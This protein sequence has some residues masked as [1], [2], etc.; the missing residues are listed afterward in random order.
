MFLNETNQQWDL[1]IAA[2]ILQNL[3]PARLK[4]F[5]EESSK[6]CKYLAANIETNEDIRSDILDTY[7]GT[8]EIKEI[9]LHHTVKPPKEW[10]SILS[11]YFEITEQKEEGS[12]IYLLGTSKL[13]SKDFT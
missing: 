4:V 2:D 5:L 9:S 1:C 12:F 10:I 11:P 8:K 6:K 3:R 7:G 13:F